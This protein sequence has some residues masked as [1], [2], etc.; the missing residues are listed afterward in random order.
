MEPVERALVALTVEF[1]MFDKLS[2]LSAGVVR[3]SRLKKVIA[4]RTTFITLH[5]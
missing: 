2:K 3:V 5:S 1:A 4:D